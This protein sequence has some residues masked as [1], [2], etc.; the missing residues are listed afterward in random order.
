MKNE[1]IYSVN[2]FVN[3]KLYVE[4]TL[5]VLVVMDITLMLVNLQI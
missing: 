2:I 4:I 3:D 5:F 1:R